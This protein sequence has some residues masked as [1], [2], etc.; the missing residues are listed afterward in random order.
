MADRA[1]I[2][3]MCLH[4]LRGLPHCTG[5]WEIDS[6]SMMGVYGC[7][8]FWMMHNWWLS[9]LRQ[10]GAFETG[11]L[12][13]SSTAAF[14]QWEAPAGRG[15]GITRRQGQ[16]AVESTIATGASA[17][18]DKMMTKWWPIGN[19]FLYLQ[20]TSRLLFCQLLGCSCRMSC[21]EI[22]RRSNC[23]LLAH[24]QHSAFSKYQKDELRANNA[25]VV[26]VSS[27][28]HFFCTSADVQSIE[29]QAGLIESSRGQLDLEETQRTGSTVDTM[30]ILYLSLNVA[31]RQHD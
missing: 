29:N 14:A 21:S 3:Y 5:R 28:N 31:P 26:D 10:M 22:Q 24:V 13:A 15:I 27:S 17:T 11:C 6:L 23:F 19:N 9:L 4:F 18:H 30:V 20:N 8:D 2:L 25:G 16:T 7:L 12:A 1:D